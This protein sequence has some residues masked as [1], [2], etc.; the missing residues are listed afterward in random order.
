MMCYYLNVNFQGQKVKLVLK[1]SVECV[2]GNGKS[3]DKTGA[4]GREGCV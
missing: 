1:N 4:S 2:V 3:G